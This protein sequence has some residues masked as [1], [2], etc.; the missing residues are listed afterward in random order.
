[1]LSIAFKNHAHTVTGMRANVMPLARISI[2]VVLKFSALN[3]AASEKIAAL[4]SQTFSPALGGRKNDAVMP[5][6]EHTVSH[7]EAKFSVGNAISRAPICSGSRKFPNPNC[8]AAV[9][10]KNTINEPCSNRTAA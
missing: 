4:A 2:V 7:N 1:M 5:T 3:N 8:G 6:S 9:S 10:T